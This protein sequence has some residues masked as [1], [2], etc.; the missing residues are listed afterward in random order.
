MLGVLGF[1]IGVDKDVVQVNDDVNIKQVGEERVKKSLESRRSI[2]EAFWDD[3]EV[4]R[5]IASLKR[6]FGLIAL[7][8]PEKMVSMSEIKFGID[9]CL[10]RCV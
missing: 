10:P 9:T 4:V 8:N 3:S 6:S 7:S 5:S 2:G 1:V